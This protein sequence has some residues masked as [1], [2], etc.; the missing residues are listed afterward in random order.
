MNATCT[1]FSFYDVG[2]VKVVKPVS[3]LNGKILYRGSS[4]LDFFPLPP[5][6]FSQSL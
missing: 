5:A 4:S 2:A 3:H 6:Y 1:L